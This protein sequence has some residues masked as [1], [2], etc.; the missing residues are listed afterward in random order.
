MRC[1]APPGNGKAV[2][3]DGDRYQ[4]RFDELASQGHDVH[5]EAAFV[6]AMRPS[7]VLDAGCGTGRVA[8]ELAHRGVEVVGVDFDPSMLSTAR[9]LAPDVRWVD[10]DLARLDL[11]RTFDVV[12]MAGNVLLFTPQGT[13]AAVVAGCARHIG[14]GGA[15]VSGFQLGRGYDLAD[16]DEQCRSAGLGLEHRWATWDR[17]PWPGDGG[18]AVSVHRWSRPVEDLP[19]VA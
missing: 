6:M 1:P 8:I 5:G 15:L 7:A 18:Y 4:R 12:L 17:G 13:H 19:G 11:G 3:W 16:Y 10:S 14:P 9:R 2:T